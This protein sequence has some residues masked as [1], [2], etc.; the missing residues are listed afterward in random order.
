MVRNRT[1]FFG[2]LLTLLTAPAGAGDEPTQFEAKI[3]PILK[4]HCW[5]CHGEAQELKGGIDVRLVRFLLKGGDTGAAVVPGD[6]AASL[7]YQRIA[8]GEMPPG[9]KKVSPEELE[10]IARWIDSGATTRRTLSR[11]RSRSAKK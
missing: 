3:R 2:L 11:K 1:A 10:Q 4:A 7:L 8:A 5:Q 6:H 9:D